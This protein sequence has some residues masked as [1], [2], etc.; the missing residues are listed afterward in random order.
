MN[1]WTE[2]SKVEHQRSIDRALRRLL[3]DCHI[4]LVAENEPADLESSKN[5]LRLLLVDGPGPEPGA[6]EHNRYTFPFMDAHSPLEDVCA[7][8]LWGFKTIGEV[9][10]AEEHYE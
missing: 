2:Q 7:A 4:A 10:G 8:G 5:Y 6:W 1:Q 3:N 9:D